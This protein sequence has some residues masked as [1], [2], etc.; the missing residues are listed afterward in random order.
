[1]KILFILSFFPSVTHAAFSAGS[2]KPAFTLSD[3]FKATCPADISTISQFDP[4][5]VNSANNQESDEQNTWVAIYR[6]SNN[7][8]SV[9]IQ[10]DFLNAM[11]IATSI[12]TDGAS[13]SPSTAM[14]SSSLT[15]QIETSNK[16]QS[17]SGIMARTPVAV[18][19]ICPSD[20]SGK[21]VI[22]NMRCSLIKEDTND[23]CDGNSE[24]SEA[25]SICIDELILYHLKEGREFDG[26]IRT[27]ATIHQGKL[28]DERGFKEV[29]E[30]SRDMATHISSLDSS[31]MK[32]AERAVETLSK[33]PGA[34]DRALK[35]L[36]YLGRQD[37]KSEEEKNAED[38]S[39]SDGDDYD[40]W[41]TATIF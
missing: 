35:I 11:R 26:A 4:S 30:L 22:E 13:A 36:N 38:D 34:R 19:K 9:L 18:A 17:P 24:H 1:M 39:N 33:S 15:S 21:W 7:L 14:D 37:P 12:Q 8:P 10:D 32:Y 25:I 29:E 23:S 6:S 31:L 3:R 20:F 41:A 2:N 28:L 27:K 40:P 16:K 5:L